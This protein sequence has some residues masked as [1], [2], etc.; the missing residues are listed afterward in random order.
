MINWQLSKQGIRWPVSPDRTA[1]SSV[2]PS[3]SSIFL[4]LSVDKLPVSNDR[5]LKFIF[6][7]DSYEICCVSSPFDGLLVVFMSLWPRTIKILIS[8]WPRTQKFS[9]FFKNTGGEDLLLP[10]GTRWS[11]SASNF[12]SLIGQNL[13]GEFM[14]K[15]YAASWKLFT[16]TAC[17]EADRV[18][19]QLVMFLTVFFHWM[20]KMKYSC[21]QESPVIHGWF[22]YS[23]F[24]WETRRLSKFGNPISDGIVFVFHLA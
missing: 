5:S 12:Y 1:G 16:L 13:T 11:R 7:N 3:R 10:W 4:K 20:Y 23:V 21:Y 19:C 17:A 18:L 9:Q 2:D 22:I 14:R 8:N 24:G 15:I 6:S